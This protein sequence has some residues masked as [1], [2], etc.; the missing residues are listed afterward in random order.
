MAF[1]FAFLLYL[2]KNM[3][4]LA[5]LGILTYSLDE[6]FDFDVTTSPFEPLYAALT[7]LWGAYFV[8]KWSKK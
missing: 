8:G 7:V 1:Y 2:I 6:I 4:I 3:A 5:I